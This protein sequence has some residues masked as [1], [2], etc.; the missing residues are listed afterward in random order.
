MVITSMRTLNLQEGGDCWGIII[1][2]YNNLS[3]KSKVRLL[4]NTNNPNPNSLLLSLNN[5]H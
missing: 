1:V 3:I 5:N 2:S 4:I